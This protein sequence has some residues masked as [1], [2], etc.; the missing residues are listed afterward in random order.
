MS[1][2]LV[3]RWCRPT[4]AGDVFVPSGARR[5]HSFLREGPHGFVLRVEVGTLDPLALSMLPSPSK[6]WFPGGLGLGSVR[7]RCSR[8]SEVSLRV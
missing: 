1:E 4:R 2:V 8:L 7:T 3:L 6:A 5:R